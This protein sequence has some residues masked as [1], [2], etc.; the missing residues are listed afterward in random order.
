[1]EETV[2]RNPE[3]MDSAEILN[4]PEFQQ[5][6]ETQGTERESLEKF[7]KLLIEGDTIQEKRSAKADPSQ[8]PL[9]HLLVRSRV[10]RE[11]KDDEKRNTFLA[12]LYC[13]HTAYNIER[14]QQILQ[15]EHLSELLSMLQKL[16]AR[17][18]QLSMLEIQDFLETNDEKLQKTVDQLKK[19]IEAIQISHG[20]PP[21]DKADKHDEWQKLLEFSADLTNHSNIIKIYPYLKKIQLLDLENEDLS[22]QGQLSNYLTYLQSQAK[23]LQGCLRLLD[24][25]K[26]EFLS[27]QK[28]ETI[29]DW[30]F[31]DDLKHLL[32]AQQFQREYVVTPVPMEIKITPGEDGVSPL[33]QNVDQ[34]QLFRALLYIIEEAFKEEKVTPETLNRHLESNKPYLYLRVKKI[35]DHQENDMILIVVADMGKSV[36]FEKIEAD[37][38]RKI[39]NGS[40]RMDALSS[41]DRNKKLHAARKI[42]QDN[43]GDI[44]C[45]PI[46]D[47][48]IIFLIA[49]PVK[50][51]ENPYDLQFVE[52]KLKSHPHG[53]LRIVDETSSRVEEYLSLEIFLPP[54]DDTPP[55]EPE[56]SPRFPK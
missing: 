50:G 54:N 5:F 1:M 52:G 16:D 17:F 34:N 28:T 22:P 37:T 20:K 7:L 3:E 32:N 9:A 31:L 2:G 45:N 43:H 38:G 12:K 40:D 42:V 47:G 15:E 51:K 56:T 33:L 6:L 21:F 24:N 30:S 36:N 8:A 39:S 46:K 14:L 44:I 18:P 29:S 48:G 4:K 10:T 27:A 25:L 53:V 13:L 49:L 41:K 19:L 23:A 35:Q 55:A 11:F 26:G